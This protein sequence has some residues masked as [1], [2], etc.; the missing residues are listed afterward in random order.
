MR[1][2]CTYSLGKCIKRP[3]IRLGKRIIILINKFV[4][5]RNAAIF[6]LCKTIWTKSKNHAADALQKKLQM[7]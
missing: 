7:S 3:L 4:F 2:E 1:K 5:N 6:A